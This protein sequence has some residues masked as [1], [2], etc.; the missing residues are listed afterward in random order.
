MAA[1]D[2][3][4][5]CGPQANAHP[6]PPIAQAPTPMGVK[7]HIAVAKP[8]LLHLF[9]NNGV[10]QSRKDP[11]RGDRVRDPTAWPRRSCWR[12]QGTRSRCTK[13]AETIG[14]GARSAELTL[15]GFVHDVCSAVHPM[16]ACS[17]C[18]EQFPLARVR[19]GVG[20][21]GGAAGAPAG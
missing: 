14:G 9:Y 6:P 1:I 3:S 5:S 8:F 15:P 7:F 18:F 20:P 16:A 19:A 17:P 10:D 21:P 13:A 2:S 11:R 12:A 4:S